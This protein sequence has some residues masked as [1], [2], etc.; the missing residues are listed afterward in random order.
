MAYWMNGGFLKDTK[1]TESPVPHKK[2]LSAHPSQ[3]QGSLYTR[4][5]GILVIPGS[6]PQAQGIAFVDGVA[7][8]NRQGERTAAISIDSEILPEHLIA[9]FEFGIVRPGEEVRMLV[10]NRACVDGDVAVLQVFNRD[11]VRDLIA[12]PRKIGGNR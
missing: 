7:D 11:P 10:Q 3:W 4:C 8:T 5:L 6:N 1:D 9:S 2:T 12:A